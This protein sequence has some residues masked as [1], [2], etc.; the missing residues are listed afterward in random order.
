MKVQW[1]VTVNIK[2]RVESY[3]QMIEQKRAADAT[4]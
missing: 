4:V 1:Q 2:N 3:F